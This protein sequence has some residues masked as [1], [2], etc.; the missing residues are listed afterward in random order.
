MK[1]AI[2]NAMD[3]II[4]TGLNNIKDRIGKFLKMEKKKEDFKKQL[5]K[6]LDDK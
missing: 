5:Q 3:Y 4:E 1:S 2:E 6:M